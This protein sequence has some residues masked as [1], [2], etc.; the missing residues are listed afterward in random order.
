MPDLPDQH[1]GT[2]HAAVLAEAR[3]KVRD[4]DASAVAVMHTGHEDRSVDEIL[5]VVARVID[6]IHSEEAEIF[7]P[8]RLSQQGA[9]RRV[10]V[11]AR[12]TTPDNLR[13]GVHQTTNRAI[14]DQREIQGCH[15]ALFRVLRL[16]PHVVVTVPRSSQA[17][18]ARAFC[19]RQRATVRPGPTFTE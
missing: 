13:P 1:H 4:L 16:P 18:T 8:R 15:T 2:E 6:E 12:E 7:F 14:A 19:S 10:A 17:R 5:L 3:R 9:K 11:E